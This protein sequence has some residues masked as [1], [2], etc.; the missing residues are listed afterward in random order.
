MAGE[1]TIAFGAADF[2]AL[3]VSIQNLI[4]DLGAYDQRAAGTPFPSDGDW[5]LQPDGQVW[6]PPADLV[7]VG[8]TF[9]DVLGAH[10]AALLSQLETF[11]DG[12]C[13]ARAIFA[14]T[15]DLAA[16]DPAA[17]SSEYPQL[18]PS[19]GLVGGSP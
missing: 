5:L 18:Q 2:D 17:F 19:G 4:N 13:A 14:K 16:Y 10:A 9:G 12:L 3:I 6:A 1:P 11:F 7:S 15:S 8:K